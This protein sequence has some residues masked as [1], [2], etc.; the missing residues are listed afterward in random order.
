MEKKVLVL[1]GSV[2][3]YSAA[4]EFGE[5][6]YIKLGSNMLNVGRHIADIL[7]LLKNIHTQGYGPPYVV[8]SGYGLYV[9]L[10]IISALEIWGAIE[11]LIWDAKTHILYSH[12]AFHESYPRL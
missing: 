2:K 4:A 1:A 6:I 10:L 9:A 12:P 5:L 11:L 3:D 7:E 8:V